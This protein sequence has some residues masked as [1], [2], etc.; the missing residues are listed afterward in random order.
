MSKKN[1][2]RTASAGHRAPAATTIVR[3]RADVLRSFGLAVALGLV[4]VTLISAT[5]EASGRHR[6]HGRYHHYARS[7]FSFSFGLPYSHYPHVYYPGYYPYGPPYSTYWAP[8][9]GAIDLAVKPKKAAVYLDGQHIGRVKSYDGWPRYL[10]LE[11]GDHE[12]LFYL[13]GYRTHVESVRVQSGVV[14]KLKYRL[15]EGEATPPQ[16]VFAAR[17]ATEPPATREAPVRPES[18]PA[19]GG[20]QGWRER[21]TV[22]RDVRTA[23][24]QLRVRVT[25]P[26]AVVYLD[27]RLIGS[28]E[29]LERLHA[30]LVVDPGPHVVE[31][32]R[33]GY[34]TERLDVEATS[35]E[36]VWLEVDLEPTGR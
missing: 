15:T 3:S 25:P 9:M 18:G 36:E 10:W 13:E 16:E 23:P 35:G 34:R 5:A 1:E 7:A 28:G 24:G 14:M 27:G 20:D 12:L 22:D 21:Q 33:P 11:E 8:D 2:E 4:C 29:E 17:P 6:G 32:A 31:V 26:D 19:P 30:P